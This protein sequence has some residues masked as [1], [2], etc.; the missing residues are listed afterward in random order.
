M[1][2][3]SISAGL[4]Y[5]V[6]N[7][8]GSCHKDG[9]TYLHCFPRTL[10]GSRSRA[11]LVEGLWSSR[12]HCRQRRGSPPWIPSMHPAR[13][14]HSRPRVV[15]RYLGNRADRQ[16][17]AKRRQ[18]RHGESDSVQPYTHSTAEFV[19]FHPYSASLVEATR[20]S[21][22]SPTLCPASGPKS[23]TGTSYEGSRCAPLS[24]LMI[25][26]HSLV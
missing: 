1:E 10:T 2:T 23:S 21:N 11:R 15:S 17:P 3:H 5:P 4:D 20:M 22:R 12:V 6:S 7:D 18:R 8:L 9:T 19:V 24:S 25:T 26:T 16:D 13:G 14:Y